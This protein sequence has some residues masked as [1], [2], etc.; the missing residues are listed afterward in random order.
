[1]KIEKFDWANLDDESSYKRWKEAKLDNYPV[2]LG[3]LIVEVKNLAAMSKPELEKIKYLIAKTNMA[4]YVGP[5]SGDADESLPG[6]V[7]EQLGLTKY[8]INP[9]ADDAGV[10]SLTPREPGSGTGVFDY[11]P[12]SYNAIKWHTDGY[13]NF[14]ENI[15]RSL[16]LHCVRPAKNGGE[17]DLL[18]HEIVYMLLRDQSED[19]IEALMENDAMT[20]PA[21]IENGK[22][23]RPDQAGPVFIS[24]TDGGLTARY[25]HRSKNV[26]WK[27]TPGVSAAVN[28]LRK[29]LD[30]NPP[31]SFRGKLDCG[32]GLICNNVF[33][34]RA[35][36]EKADEGQPERL[37]YRMRFYDRI[38]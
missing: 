34:T 8:D 11:I 9:E 32:Q 21:R 2:S 12:Y 22:V 29:I 19:H 26:S 17:N 31:Y 35:N 23:K 28:A 7:M 38:T 10:T 25:T 14:Q 6:K 24:D 33:H 3:D 37:L 15:V 5:A 13:Y 4:I 1:M 18:D 27:T 36:F 20:I 30:N 16:T